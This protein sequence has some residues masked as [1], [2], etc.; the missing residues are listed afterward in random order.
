VATLIGT[1][2]ARVTNNSTILILLVIAVSAIVL[3]SISNKLVPVS[4]YPIVILVMAFFLVFHILLI[5][6]F[7]IGY[8]I[9][10][11]AYFAQTTLANSLWDSTILNPY[12]VMVSITILPVIFSTFLNYDIIWVLKIVF[13]LIYLLVPIALYFAYRKQTSPVVAFLGVFLVILMEG[14]YVQMLGLARQMIGEFFLVLCLLL[15]VDNKIDQ[16]HKRLI[17]LFFSIAILFSHY[18]VFYIFLYFILIVYSISGYFKHSDNKEDRLI[19]G[20][21]ILAFAVMGIAWYLFIVP[22]AS[23]SLSDALNNMYS[24]I[25]SNTSGP[26]VGGLIPIATSVQRQFAQYVFYPLQIFIAIGLIALISGRKNTRFNPEYSALAIGG[27]FILIASIALPNFAAGL[28]IQR[29][30]HIALLILAPFCVLGGLE[31]ELFLESKI[32][33]PSKKINKIRI[34]QI[35]K[36]WTSVIA[37]M[38]IFFF[39]FQVGFVYEVTG[40]TPLSISLS[41]NRT[42]FPGPLLLDA[43]AREIAASKWLSKN[44][45]N[46]SSVFADSIS[47]HYIE[48]Y[49]LVPPQKIAI[50]FP[51]AV[52]SPQNSSFYFFGWDTFERNS[53][54]G[55]SEMWNLTEYSP[56]T[57]NYNLIFSDGGSNIYVRP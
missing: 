33:L 30:Y 29:F 25:I 7:L 49:G 47:N 36:V 16:F 10:L 18:S 53:I 3:C 34:P 21:F 42:S 35:K 37:I 57:E 39:L 6:N 51:G 2:V 38:L 52:Y 56:I 17:L 55:Y 45:Q 40:D 24:A 31:I 13:P 11:E 8:D 19:T 20:K 5:S 44:A 46:I 23:T 28:N 12:S 15:I 4:A 43:D 50:L 14:F 48:S 26:G 27:L 1:E 54:Y 41:R 22:G 9:H 32:L